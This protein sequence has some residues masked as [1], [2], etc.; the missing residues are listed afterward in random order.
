MKIHDLHNIYMY[1]HTC[2]VPVCKEGTTPWFL[3]LWVV[4]SLPTLQ[5]PLND[6]TGN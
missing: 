1:V 2:N 4:A 3:E 6:A 5:R